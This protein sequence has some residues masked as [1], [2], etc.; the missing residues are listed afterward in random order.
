MN[1]I[2][3]RAR[4][5]ALSMGVI[6]MT[7]APAAAQV[8]G[9]G[10][11]EGLYACDS[12][13]AGVPSTWARPVSVAVRQDGT[14]ISAELRYTDDTELGREF[15][16]Y[17]GEV[18]HSPNQNFVTGYL[19]SCGG[20]FPAQELVRLF[21]AATNADS[22]AFSADG[23]WVSS[24]VPNIPGLTVQ[25]CKWSLRRT[26]ETPTPIRPCQTP[27]DAQRKQ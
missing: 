18:A 5:I 3:R 16:V 15:S 14:K 1:E 8:S 10:T 26:S 21:P 23:I 24:E 2:K 20:T 13:T 4:P 11:Y 25:S 9:T 7:C 17:R 22:F 27:A 6:A 19:S 12:V